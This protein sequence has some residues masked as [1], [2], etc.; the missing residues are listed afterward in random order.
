MEK[1]WLAPDLEI[2]KEEILSKKIKNNE[3]KPEIIIIHELIL[4]YLERLAKENQT[5]GLIGIEELERLQEMQSDYG[6]SLQYK[7]RKPTSREINETKEEEIDRH[8]RDM[9][10]DEG[11]TIITGSLNTTKI[12][13]A[14]SVP[15]L[16][17]DSNSGKEKLE[18]EKYFEEETMSVHIKEEVPVYAKK[19]GPGGWEFS[20]VSKNNIERPKVQAIAKEILEQANIRKDGFIETERQ[21]STIVQIGKLRIVIT[22]PP[23]SDGWEITAVR[24]V[25]RLDLKD[26]EIS[27]NLKKRLE[28]KAEG[29]LISGSPGMGKT[30]FA[31]ALA[32][33][34]AN[35]GKIIKT[36][37]APR[38]L[39]LSQ[40]I[41]QY[42]ISYGSN[43][44]LHDILL[45]SRP[46]YTIFDEVRNNEDFHL[47]S[48]L[49]LSGI[50]FIG[51][52]H[53]TKAIDSIQRFVGRIEL[54]VI[55]Q[56]VDTVIFI[57]KGKIEKALSL[58]MIVKVPAGMT[59][60]DL[61]RP[62]V[63]VK[64]FETQK[65]DYEVYTYGEQTIVIPVK[66]TEEQ[67]SGIR[68]LAKNELERSL[69]K[70]GVKKVE[71]LSENKC[72]ALIPEEKIPELIGKQGK[73]ISEIEK[74]IG[75]G[76][77]VQSTYDTQPESSE[78]LYFT[79]KI[80]AKNIV[81]EVEPEHANKNVKIYV[82]EDY[83]LAGQVSK[84]GMVKIK[85]NNKIGKIILDSLNSDEIVKIYIDE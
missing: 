50:G 72:R 36:V 57:N 48:D 55:P 1:Q 26:Y 61:A 4:Y 58:E 60:S 28:E 71:I 5:T 80:T 15:F 41:T 67:I 74:S 83:L 51:V 2:I 22:K 84:K 82:N 40:A 64:D 23:F 27:D 56:V 76:I 34:L 31:S 7:G 73:N 75:I 39:V 78:E 35:K 54:G 37:E 62:V 30:T 53:A 10:Y 43:E 17:E 47:F 29:I 3:I 25:C 79:S 68:R 42:S 12:A 44:E 21:G 9:A 32:E 38:D 69:R 59:E 19:G 45:L 85:R 24:P 33:D 52:M 8:V 6:F 63:E 65:T 14:K 20:Q 18:L 49:R 13:K 77:D 66:E 46:D 11:A 16:L 81:F 70:Y